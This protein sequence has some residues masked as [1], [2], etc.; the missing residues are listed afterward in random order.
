MKL[1]HWPILI[2]LLVLSVS[3]R[4]PQSTLPPPLGEEKEVMTA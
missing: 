2:G 1:I 3:R 4:P